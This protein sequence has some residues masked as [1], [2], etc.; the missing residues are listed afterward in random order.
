LAHHAGLSSAAIAQIESGRRQDVRLG[1]LVALA[2]ALGVSVDY[3][4]GSTA[5]VVPTLLEHRVLIY[6]S[7]AEYVASAVPF[8]V[9][10]ITRN[11]CV[12][13]VAGDWQTRVLRDALG[14]EAARVEFYDSA[15]WYVLPAG[16]LDRYR[17]FV[18]QR[19]ELGAQWIRIIGEP[20]WAG[21]SQVEVARWT[22]YESMLNLSL[23]SAPATIMCPYDARCVSGEIL[24]GAY[25]THPEV[26]E[27]DQVSASVGYREPQDLLLALP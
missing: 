8:L 16:A 1:T 10:G 11:D 17:S 3:L 22:R 25:H 6:D 27:G 7:D 2:S 14:V 21:R 13:V 18:K 24:A 19:F 9:D 23:A 12:A 5:T 15:E 20:V 26:S 4:V